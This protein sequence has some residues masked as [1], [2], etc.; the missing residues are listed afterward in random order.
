MLN[1]KRVDNGVICNVK[2]IAVYKYLEKV[3]R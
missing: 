1:A 2:A 3:E